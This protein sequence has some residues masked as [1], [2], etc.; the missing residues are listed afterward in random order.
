MNAGRHE[1]RL[2]RFLD[3]GLYLVTSQEVSR[4]RKTLDIVQSALSGGVRLVQLREKSLNAEEFLHLARQVREITAAS[5]ALLIINDRIDVALA[6]DADGVHLGHEDASVAVARA[7]SPDFIIG[8]SCHSVKEARQ[9]ETDGASYIN[10]GPLFSTGTKEWQGEFLG[11]TA[12]QRISNEVSIPFTV[13]GG[14]K[15]EHI[16]SLV[17][18]G[19]RTIAV[20]TAVTAADNPA[21]AARD[22]LAEMAA[23]TNRSTT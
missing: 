19:A 13:M 5:Q 12:I 2:E 21:A 11:L 10:I 9:A 1:E 3:A 17:A 18:E 14:I 20:V 8:A 6:V 15:K 4:G 16:A 22:L 23:T 7:S